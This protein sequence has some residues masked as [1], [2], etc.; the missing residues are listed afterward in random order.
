MSGPDLV[1]FFPSLWHALAWVLFGACVDRL[2]VKR[3]GW[4]LQSWADWFLFGMAHWLWPLWV[5]G[6]GVHE[7]WE[8]VRPEEFDCD[9]CRDD[10]WVP[11][12]DPVCGREHVGSE[13]ICPTC[14]G[15]MEVET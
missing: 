10:G 9:T 5:L 6:L 4:C 15:V 14:D 13:H 12:T 2:I 7:V 11:C 8:R 3:L 1:S